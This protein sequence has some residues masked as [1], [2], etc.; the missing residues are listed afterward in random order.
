MKATRTLVVTALAMVAALTAALCQPE[1][2]LAAGC[3]QCPSPAFC[4]DGVANSGACTSSCTAGGSVFITG[5]TCIS[6][7]C[8]APTSTPTPTGTATQT[9]TSTPTST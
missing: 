4:N 3:C 6:G 5:G 2:A 8:T 1:T 9:S 7:V